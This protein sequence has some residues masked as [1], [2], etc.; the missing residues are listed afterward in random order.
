MPQTAMR[1]TF[2]RWPRP[3]PHMTPFPS[4]SIANT[5]PTANPAS[6]DSVQCSCT[7][8]APLCSSFLPLVL[9]PMGLKGEDDLH[10]TL[11]VKRISG[12]PPEAELTE[13]ANAV[14]R[15]WTCA[16]RDL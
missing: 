6:F 9:V 13:R 11:S 1:I 3:I 15:G 16:E 8:L 4:L 12:A 14:Q 5:T 7:L 2:E 10:L